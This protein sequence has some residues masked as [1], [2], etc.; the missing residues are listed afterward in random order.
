[1]VA[2]AGVEEEVAAG[3]DAVYDRASAWEAARV[4]W[5]TA[6]SGRGRLCILAGQRCASSAYWAGRCNGVWLGALW[7]GGGR[8]WSPRS[9]A[10]VGHGAWDGLLYRCAKRVGRLRIRSPLRRAMRDGV[11]TSSV[12]KPQD[13]GSSLAAALAG[14]CRGFSPTQTMAVVA[15]E[16]APGQRLFYFYAFDA[17]HRNFPAISAPGYAGFYSLTASQTALL[18]NRGVTPARPMRL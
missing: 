8:P 6:A 9:R 18:A 10:R 16:R 15:Q 11:V 7:H 3:S 13:H 5:P 1:V 17:Q 2:G 12:V 14:R 4:R